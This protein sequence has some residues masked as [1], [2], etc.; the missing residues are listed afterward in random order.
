MTISITHPFTSAKPQGTDATKV[1]TNDWNAN[2]IIAMSSGYFIGRKTAGD[3]AAEELDL[4]YLY[5][6][7]GFALTNMT[8]GI[9]ATVTG[10]AIWRPMFA[11]AIMGV[12][13]SLYTA[14]TSG[15]LLQFDVLKNGTSIFSTKPTFDNTEKTTVT[16]LT[17]YALTSTPI[18]F[19]DDDE[20]R[21]DITAFGDGTAK[22][23]L[24][25]LRV[26]KY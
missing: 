3:G 25:Q 5:E 14:Q 2:H 22:G 16:A 4:A 23:L 11:G 7:F 6:H 17:Q 9:N 21:F 10:A 12:R 20:I 1:R 26:R 24:A 8:T 19:A 13:G 18:T 15:T